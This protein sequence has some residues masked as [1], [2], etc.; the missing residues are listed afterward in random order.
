MIFQEKRFSW[1]ILLTDQI[2]L[3]LLLEILGKMC[4]VIVCFPDCDAINFE[5]ILSFL[6]KPFSYMTKKEP[7]RK[8]KYLGNEKKDLLR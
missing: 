4:I 1:Q 3:S 6:I 8:F 5:I 2:S 7:A